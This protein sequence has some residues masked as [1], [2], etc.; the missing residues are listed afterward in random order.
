MTS[1]LAVTKNRMGYQSAI[2]DADI[3]GPSILKAFGLKEK[4]PVTEIG[5]FL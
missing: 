5:Y 2:Q 4:A 1:L 3:T